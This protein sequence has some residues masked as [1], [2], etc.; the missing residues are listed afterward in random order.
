MLSQVTEGLRSI[1]SFS[2][3]DSYWFI[4][5]FTE[6][7]LNEFG[8]NGC[9]RLSLGVFDSSWLETMPLQSS[10]FSKRFSIILIVWACL[11]PL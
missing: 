7:W 9:G 8:T 2:I 3:D 1:I 5:V 10:A 11:S 4:G 6:L